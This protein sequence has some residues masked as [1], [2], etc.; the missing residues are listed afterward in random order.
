VDTWE[1][2]T[3]IIDGVSTTLTE[4]QAYYQVAGDGGRKRAPALAQLWAEVDADG[5]VL[6]HDYTDDCTICHDGSVGS[7]FAEYHTGYDPQIYTADGERY[8]DTKTTTLTSVTKTGNVLSF[9]FSASDPATVPLL[10]VS[11]YGYDTK[12]MLVPAHNRSS[13][14]RCGSS[15]CRLEY[16]VG[17]NLDT[18]T[19][20]DN[21]AFVETATGTPGSWSVSLDLAAYVPDVATGLPSIATLISQGKVKRV[22]VSVLPTLVIGGNEVAVVGSSKTY[23]VSGTSA[24]E[25]EDWFKGDEAIASTAKCNACHDV[26]GT[27]FHGPD[28]G[29][30]GVEGCRHCH[31]TMAGGSHLE[32]QGRPMESYAHAIHSFQQF[33]PGDIDFTD[34]VEAARYDEDVEFIFPY[35]TKLACESC[36]VENPAK[37]N[38]PDQSENMPGVLSAADTFQGRD[39][40]IGAVPSYVTGPGQ[41]ACGSCHRSMAINEDDAGELAAMN[42]HW[43]ANGYMVNNA[44]QPPAPAANWVYQ[45]IEKIMAMF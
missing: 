41:R 21:L 32:M 24:A 27:T 6:F 29:S 42:G 7:T 37:Y 30:V 33:D 39:R 10:A 2:G 19:T 34:P 35:F 26:L 16:T 17:T 28:Y 43:S 3:Y 15:G 31:F 18:S 22:E 4:D 23:D 44:T 9:Q 20:N 1:A 11:F 40:A 14:P 12:D 25:V 36:H 13:T 38:V 5:P 8:T 45:V